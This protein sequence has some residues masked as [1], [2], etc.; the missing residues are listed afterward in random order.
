M[1]HFLVAVLVA[2]CTDKSARRCMLLQFGKV[3]GASMNTGVAR[4]CAVLHKA[5]Q[6]AENSS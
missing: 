1:V 6:V 2:L 3:K 4:C 5:A